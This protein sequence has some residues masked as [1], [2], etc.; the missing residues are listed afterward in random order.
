MLQPSSAP[1]TLF[2]S[3][4][5]SAFSNNFFNDKWILQLLSTDALVNV[6]VC[7]G[8]ILNFLIW[9]DYVELATVYRLG[10]CCSALTTNQT[11]GVCVAKRRRA[12][13]FVIG[14]CLTFVRILFEEKEGLSGWLNTAGHIFS[15]NNKI[16]LFK[17]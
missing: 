8:E 2:S 15:D 17:A 14:Y 1:F 10:S 3:V 4:Q 6:S 7:R 9:V 16:P 11:C 13:D 12:L 5:C